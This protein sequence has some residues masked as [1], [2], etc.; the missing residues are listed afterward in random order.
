MNLALDLLQAYWRA[1]AQVAILYGVVYGVLRFLKGTHGEGILRGLAFLA[2][3]G[4]TV[5]LVIAR[6]AGLDQ[7]NFLLT[8]FL[9]TSVFALIIIFQPELRRGLVRIS[10]T[11]FL[12]FMFKGETDP[13]GEVVDAAARMARNKVGAIVAIEREDGLKDYIERGTSIDAVVSQKLL[14]S[15]FFPGSPLHDGA[16]VIRENRVAAAGCL[17]PLTENVAAIRNLG[18]RHRAG[19]GL[20]EQ[21]D[22]IVV[23]VSEETGTISLALGGQLT[24]N[25]DK[26]SLDRRLRELYANA[27]DRESA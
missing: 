20:S 2:L 3:V 8:A 19:I 18:T 17:F 12:K 15:I 6:W 22:A 4:F 16:I 1:A 7:I 25:L 9:Q 26:E 23:I 5:L 24:R 27:S 21:G 11:P 10:Q 13:I 14:E